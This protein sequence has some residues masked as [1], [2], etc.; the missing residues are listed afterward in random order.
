MLSRL[1]AALPS[2]KN[3]P[4]VRVAVT[5][6]AETAPSSDLREIGLCLA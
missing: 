2:L 1:D 5:S 6:Y 4:A 3:G